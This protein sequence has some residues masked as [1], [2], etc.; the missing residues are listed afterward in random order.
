MLLRLLDKLERRYGKFAIRGIMTYIVIGNLAVFLLQR[1]FPLREMMMLIPA[2]VLR[3]EV[4]RLITYIFIPP[5]TN[6]FF[7]LF[8]LYF[9][10]MI[11]NSLEREWGSFKLNV[12]Y[13]IG[14]IGTTIASMFT[15]YSD[16]TYLNLSLFLAFAYLFPNFEILIFF[17]LPV[18]VK[19]LAWLNL[20]YV[21]VTVIIGSPGAKVAAIVSLLNYF[22]F[23]GEDIIRGINNKRKA[24][25][26]RRNYFRQIEE[27]RKANQ[28]N[29]RR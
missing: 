26:N 15:G 1:V 9:Y 3:G 20:A 4:W 2:R 11:G 14:M 25:Y 10:Y 16:A 7:I 24:Y 18:K 19:Y 8:V 5:P 27:G 23:F 29:I 28:R 12:Y 6:V 22:V 17:I 21:V 13:L